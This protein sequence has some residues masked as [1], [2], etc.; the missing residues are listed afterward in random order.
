MDTGV[1]KKPIEDFDKYERDLSA[2]LTQQQIVSAGSMRAFDK[3]RNEVVFAEGEEERVIR[4]AISFMS[5]GIWST[6]VNWKEILL[7]L[8]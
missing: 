1:A 8:V 7:K 6:Y 5:S 4:A 2:D 3:P